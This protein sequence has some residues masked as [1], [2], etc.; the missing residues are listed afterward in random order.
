[1]KAAGLDFVCVSSGGLTAGTRNPTTPGY[2][3]PIAKIIRSETG[4]S[5]RTVGLIVTPK[6]A[7][8]IIADGDADMVSMAR[9][10]LDDPH[11]AW[12]AAYELGAEVAIPPQYLRAGPK[13]WS[14]AKQ[15]R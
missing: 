10:M 12:H 6:Q 1:L 14:G 9:A 15:F 8:S 11:W 3:A 2:N 4:I 5:T 7:E 13:L